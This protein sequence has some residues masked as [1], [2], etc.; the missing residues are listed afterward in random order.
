MDVKKVTVQV[1]SGADDGKIFTLTKLPFTL[2]RLPDD[3][4][5]L[6]YD[7]RVSRRHARVSGEGDKYFIE[8]IGAESKGSTNGTAINDTKIS[9]RTPLIPGDMVLLGTV[10][11]QFNFASAR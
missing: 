7:T 11:V 2:G 6:A 5:S 9:A 8:D 3:D 10:W 1:M 4:V